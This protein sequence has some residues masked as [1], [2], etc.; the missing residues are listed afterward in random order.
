M[1]YNREMLERDLSECDNLDQMVSKLVAEGRMT[2]FQAVKEDEIVERKRRSCT[3][4]LVKSGQAMQNMRDTR[5]RLHSAVS[6]HIPMSLDEA[7]L[8]YNGAVT[9]L[10]RA[11]VAGAHSENEVLPADPP[12]KYAQVR[13]VDGGYELQ[14]GKNYWVP[15]ARGELSNLERVEYS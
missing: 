5:A 15:I 13:R 14:L 4:K 12:M 2:G 1:L 6:G 10:R 3:M 9:Q 7:T 11:S 8:L